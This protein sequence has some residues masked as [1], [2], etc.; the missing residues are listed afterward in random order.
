[1]QLN[2][3]MYLFTRVLLLSHTLTH[4]KTKYS[5]STEQT[6]REARG[7][8]FTLVHCAQHAS[9]A[10]TCRHIRMLAAKHHAE[11]LPV[12]KETGRASVEP[13]C[14]PALAE[15]STLRCVDRTP[16]QSWVGKANA[17]RFSKSSSS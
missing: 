9:D 6:T 2:F 10:G 12:R 7:S 11:L 5:C 16:C 3:F 17:H 4:R 13:E 15:D 14:A 8:P 1:M